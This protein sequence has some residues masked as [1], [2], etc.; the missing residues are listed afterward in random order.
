MATTFKDNQGRT[1]TLAVNATSIKR[2]KADLGIYLPDVLKGEL[3]KQLIADPILLVDTVYSLCRPDAQAAGITAEQFGEAMAGDAIEHATQALLD[4]CVNF[5]QN[6]RDRAALGRIVSA[7]W[8]T[9]EKARDL[10]ETR[11]DAIQIEKVMEEAMT[12]AWNERL[13]ASSGSVP[14]SSE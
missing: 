4:E 9:M 14:G 1:W 12:R 7:L 5:S 11:L 2:V 6:P 8:K 13:T 3:V 10:V